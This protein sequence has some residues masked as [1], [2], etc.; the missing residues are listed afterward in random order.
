MTPLTAWKTRESRQAAFAL[1]SKLS[2]ARELLGRLLYRTG[3]LEGAVLPFET[4]VQGGGRG[5]RSQGWM[6][7]YR[8]CRARHARRTG[9]D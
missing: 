5:L 2:A 6:C 1:D 8:R 9:G 7:W 3:D 4:V